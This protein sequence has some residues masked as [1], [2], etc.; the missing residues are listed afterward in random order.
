[1]A[2][3]RTDRKAALIALELSQ[4]TIARA[5]GCDTTLVCHVLAGRRWMGPAGRR[6]MAYVA[7]KLKLPILDVFPY[8]FLRRGYAKRAA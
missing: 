8:A 2:F 4:S 6:V 1:M 3:T 7:W 5:C